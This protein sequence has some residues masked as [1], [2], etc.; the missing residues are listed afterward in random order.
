MEST[1]YFVNRSIVLSDQTGSRLACTNITSVSS[2]NGSAQSNLTQPA[3][4][5]Y[6]QVYNVPETSSSSANNA[7]NSSSSGIGNGAVTSV[8]SS[9]TKTRAFDYFVVLGSASVV[10]AFNDWSPD[11]FVILAATIRLGATNKRF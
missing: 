10:F 2:G 7:T 8:T 9:S 4:V 5:T 3:P 11:P 6:A 1:E